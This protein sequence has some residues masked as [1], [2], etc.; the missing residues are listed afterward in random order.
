MRP[1]LLA[2]ALERCVRKWTNLGL[3]PELLQQLLCDC[4]R[5]FHAWGQLLRS[6]L[7]LTSGPRQELFTA[8][9]VWK[10]GFGLSEPRLAGRR[11]FAGHDIR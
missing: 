11:W 6:F 4:R 9:P 7:P 8:E 2:A 5:K 1:L 3:A 10:L